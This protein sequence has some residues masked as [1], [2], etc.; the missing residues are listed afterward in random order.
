MATS[1]TLPRRSSVLA[2]VTSIRRELTG[3]CH[4][5]AMKSNSWVWSMGSLVTARRPV[6]QDRPTGLSD[7]LRLILTH[8]RHGF[9]PRQYPRSPALDSGT[10]PGGNTP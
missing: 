8:L 1:G 3:F 5:P 4:W 2:D 9:G 7:E 6:D 10:Q